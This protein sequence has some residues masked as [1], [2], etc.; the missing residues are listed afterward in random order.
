MMEKIRSNRR[1]K[2]IED[3]GILGGEMY[4]GEE[5]KEKGLVDEV[6]S[7]V[8]ILDRYYPGSHLE[9]KMKKMGALRWVRS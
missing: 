9:I 8:E 3:E 7:M 5:A 4:Y 1:N 6:G 2:L